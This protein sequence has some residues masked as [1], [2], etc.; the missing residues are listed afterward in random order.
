[1]IKINKEP[2]QL[3]DEINRLKDE[4]YLLISKNI[5]IKDPQFIEASTKLM[6][7]INEYYK[8]KNRTNVQI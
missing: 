7:L 5:D 8:H 6:K 3:L 4:L 1:M 2:E